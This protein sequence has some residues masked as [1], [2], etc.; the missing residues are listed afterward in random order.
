L[1]KTAAERKV[2][3]FAWLSKWAMA[4]VCEILKNFGMQHASLKDVIIV[5]QG[6]GKE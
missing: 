6:W 1:P 5:R 2:R 4:V 3:L